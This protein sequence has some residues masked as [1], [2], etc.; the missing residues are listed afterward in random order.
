MLGKRLKPAHGNPESTVLCWKD[1]DMLHFSHLSAVKELLLFFQ[2]ILLR[3]LVRLLSREGL[4]PSDRDSSVI[5]V[6]IHRG[7]NS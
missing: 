5:F 6:V 2:N 7:K 4:L 3:L 1:S